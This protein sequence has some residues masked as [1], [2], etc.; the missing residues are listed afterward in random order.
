M[1]SGKF[2]LAIVALSILLRIVFVWQFVDLNKLNQWEYGEIAKNIV[3]NNGY[4]L[5]YFENDTL[6]YKYQEGKNPYPSAYMP[7]GY[8]LIILLFFFLKNTFLI[9]L[10]VVSLQIILSAAV[11]Y[12]LNQVSKK[13]FNQSI[14]YISIIIYAI[15]PEF[16]YAVV[17]FSP[18][19]IFHLVILMI[20]YRLLLQREKYQFD[21]VLP[22]LLSFLIYLR[23]EFILFVLLLLLYFAFKKYFAHTLIYLLIIIGLI[24]PWSVRNSIEFSRFVPLTTNFGQ[25]LYRGNN[26]SDVGWWG[27]EI[28]LEK[29]KKL[30]RNNSYEVHQND[31]YFARA[32]DYIKDNPSTFVK[33]IFRK[34]FE[35]WFFNLNDPRA[36]N[37]LYLVPSITVLLLF[38][39]GIIKTFN[40]DKYKFIYLFFI[41]GAIIASIFFALPRYQTMM[42]VLMVPFAAAGVVFLLDN[43]KKYLIKI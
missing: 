38:G 9:N 29:L 3:H 35:L 28:M 17:S 37:L 30:P 25:N 31:M 23:S 27:E 33:N 16:I 40:I 8:V 32:I 21:I 39:V 12:Y 4:S 18:T 26:V 5:F 13:L 43:V 19:V 34:Q 22:L 6:E 42:K 1:S 20:I 10:L 7:P 24:L 41:Q 14:A 11:V 36:L 15:L 2:I